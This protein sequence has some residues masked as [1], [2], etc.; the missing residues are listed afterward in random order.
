M[1]TP[2]KCYER[3]SSLVPRA[4]AEI[5]SRA[6]TAAGRALLY[7]LRAAVKLWKARS[8]CSPLVADKR[9]R[10]HESPRQIDHRANPKWAMG[11]RRKTEKQIGVC[12]DRRHCRTISIC[13]AEDIGYLRWRL[14]TG[15]R[16][17]NSKTKGGAGH[18]QDSL[19]SISRFESVKATA[20]TGVEFRVRCPSDRT[21][22]R[23]K[24]C[25]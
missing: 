3:S 24:A 1:K 17:R 10:S 6:A 23:K 5:L 12:N 4:W 20:P 19:G 16:A 9:S 18:A 8:H 7:S 2:S 13:Q 25:Y 15:L 14:G 11:N 21:T 22:E